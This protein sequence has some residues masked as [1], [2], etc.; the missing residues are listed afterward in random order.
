MAHYAQLDE[1]NNV[2]SVRLL[3]DFYEMNDIGE[4]D[5]EKAI[6]LLQK[7]NGRETIWKKTSYSG[8]TRGKFASDASLHFCVVLR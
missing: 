3:D 4:L 8:K 7:E 2:I 1:N 6:C 5:E